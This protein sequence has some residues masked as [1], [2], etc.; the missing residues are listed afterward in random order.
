MN[1]IIDEARNSLT[2]LKNDALQYSKLLSYFSLEVFY[3]LMES[4]VVLECVPEDLE[5]VE[6]AS[7]KAAEIFKENTFINI[8]VK[9]VGNLSDQR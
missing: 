2:S 7:K 5:L 4:D 9:V 6:V 3:H 8:N 1:E